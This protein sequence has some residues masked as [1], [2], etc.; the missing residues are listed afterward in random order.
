MF[1]LSRLR[2]PHGLEDRKIAGARGDGWIQGNSAFQK[3]Q[4]RCTH[5]FI[6]IVTACTESIH[7]Q[8]RQNLRRE[9]EVGT[10]ISRLAK[11]ADSC[12]ERENE[13]YLMECH[14]HPHSRVTITHTPRF[15]Y[16]PGSPQ[17]K[18]ACAN[19]FAEDPLREL[20]HWLLSKIFREVLLPHPSPTSILPSEPG[21]CKPYPFGF[22][23]ILPG[24][25]T[26]GAWTL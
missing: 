6:G 15:M 25:C 17:I 11:K 2:N 14:H 5:K 7:V 10:E 19:C 3:N 22:F 18:C 4:G 21:S 12:W 9:K 16:R 23:F 8:A 13:F 20:L 24:C 1:F 26:A